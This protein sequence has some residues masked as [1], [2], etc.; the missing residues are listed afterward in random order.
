MFQNTVLDISFIS[1]KLLAVK[2]VQYLRTYSDMITNVTE[3]AKI[4]ENTLLGKC[5]NFF[6]IMFSN[7]HDLIRFYNKKKDKLFIHCQK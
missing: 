2:T 5:L 7:K 1:Q 6:Y 3:I 4:H